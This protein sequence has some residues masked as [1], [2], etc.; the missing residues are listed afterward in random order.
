MSNKEI[1]HVNDS[2]DEGVDLTCLLHF[3]LPQKGSPR[4]LQGVYHLTRV[5]KLW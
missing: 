2:L 3:Q 5:S 4:K 1:I